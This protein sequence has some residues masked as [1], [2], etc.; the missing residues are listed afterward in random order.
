MSRAR[1]GAGALIGGLR[2]S[3][4]QRASEDRL[5]PFGGERLRKFERAE[6]IVPVSDG[7]RG[8]TI[9]GGEFRQRLDRQ[10]AFQQ[11]IGGMDVQMDKGGLRHQ[12][13]QGRLSRA[14]GGR[15]IPIARLLE[16]RR[17]CVG[18]FGFG[19]PGLLA[20]LDKEALVELEH[21]IHARGE[22]EIMGCD[23]R[24]H[25]GRADELGQFLENA[26]RR[27]RIEIARRLVGKED[28]PKIGR[29]HV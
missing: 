25:A 26:I 2:K 1:P 27:V 24:G 12:L 22:I 20:D 18:G 5:N 28:E 10:R 19:R 17:C 11:R 15:V 13:P 8:L 16:R 14:D 7:E 29:A 4:R 21:A 3:D 9:G 23:E 6:K